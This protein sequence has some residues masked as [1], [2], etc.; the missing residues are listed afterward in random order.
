[1]TPASRLS[2]RATGSKVDPQ[3]RESPLPA[4]TY[5]RYPGAASAPLP[6][7]YRRREPEKSVLHAVVREHLE[8]LLDQARRL[9]GEGS[10]Y[11]QWVLTFPWALRFRPGQ[12]P[13][14]S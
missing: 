13:T 4:I 6:P 9:H 1:M 2:H 8:T 14:R 3:P 12:A 5:E 10:P 11:R 7:T